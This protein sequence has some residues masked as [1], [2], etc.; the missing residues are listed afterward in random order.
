MQTELSK[1][2]PMKV[3]PLRPAKT[4]KGLQW[5]KTSF[6]LPDNFTANSYKFTYMFAE[7]HGSPRESSPLRKFS[8]PCPSYNSASTDSKAPP[9]GFEI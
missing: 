3:V 8:S 5:F 1:K 2:Y 7:K 4:E 9:L 6:Q